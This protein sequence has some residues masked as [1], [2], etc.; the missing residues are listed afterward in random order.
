MNGLKTLVF[1]IISTIIFT[2]PLAAAEAGKYG[3]FMN[4]STVGEQVDDFDYNDERI[5]IIRTADYTADSA[6]MVRFGYSLGN[7]RADLEFGVRTL[8]V[9]NIAGAISGSGDM[10]VYTAMINGAW[11]FLPVAL[12]LGDITPF[13]AFGFGG[14]MAAGKISFTNGNGDTD[15]ASPGDITPAGHVGIGGRFAFSDAAA[16]TLGYA[17]QM[18]PSDAA[19][20]GSLSPI[21]SVTLGLDYRF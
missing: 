21:H 8:D 2:A 5:G 11:D 19:E 15:Q 7:L 17:F 12:P 14:V 1:S 16:M 13:F 3:F 6:G 10:D 18:A 20:Q 9:Q 4:F